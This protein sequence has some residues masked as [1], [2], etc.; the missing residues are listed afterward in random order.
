MPALPNR[1]LTG[2]FLVFDAEDRTDPHVCRTA[3]GVRAVISDLDG[4]PFQVLT[5]AVDEFCRDVTHEFIADE[6]E[7]DDTFGVP[8]P[9]GLRRWNEGRVL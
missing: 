5:I 3:E 2:P 8:S 7:A 4:Q 9:A 1:D 6:E